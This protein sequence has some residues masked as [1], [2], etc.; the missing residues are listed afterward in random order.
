MSDG[1]KGLDALL[2]QLGPEELAKLRQR[3]AKKGPPKAGAEV[4]GAAASGDSGP[5]ARS[6]SEST[7]EPAAAPTAATTE[8]LLRPEAPPRPEHPPLSSAQVRLWWL[9]QLDPES[10]AYNV[11][12]AYRLRGPLDLRALESALHWLEARHEVL[13]TTYPETSGQPWQR[14]EEAAKVPLPVVDLAALG[15]ATAVSELA[16]EL[17]RQEAARPFRLTSGPMLR[18]LLVRLAAE[19][20]LLVVDLHHIAADQRSHELLVEELA[21]AY[22]ALAAG[23][24]L[25]IA[26]PPGQFI[27]FV[28][29]TADQRQRDEAQALEAQCRILEGAPRDFTLP[30]DRP[31]P[32]QRRGHGELWRYPLDGALS[33]P[34]VALGIRHGASPF[35]TRLALT[36][37]TL[38]RCAARDEAVLAVPVTLRD[39]PLHHVVGFF[40]NTALLRLPMADSF[41]E[42]LA[43]AVAAVSAAYDHRHL[44]FEALVEALRGR[45]DPSLSPL[46][47]VM[48]ATQPASPESVALGELELTPLPL[49]PGG[50]KLDVA[51]TFEDSAPFH[52]LMEF[53]RDL[54]DHSTLQRFIQ[55]WEGLARSLVERGVESSLESLS[56]LADSERQQLLMEW[57]GGAGGRGTAT[58]AHQLVEAQASWQPDA[59]AVIQE[60][61]STLSYG[62]LNR[63]ANRLA[64]EL[65]DLGVSAE[66][67]VALCLPRDQRL[68]VAVVAVL[69]AGAGWLPL[70]PANPPARLRQVVEDA[71]PAVLLTSA[72]LE[73]KLNLEVPITRVL[74]RELKSKA[75]TVGDTNLDLP[76]A[77]E[78]LAYVIYTSGSTGR[79]KGVEVSHGSLATVLSEL[80]TLIPLPQPLTLAALTSLAFDVSVLDLLM[81]LAFGGRLLL[82]SPQSALDGRLLARILE[83]HQ[84]NVLQATPASWRLLREAREKIEDNPLAEDF[85]AFVGGEALTP[86]LARW[87]RPRVEQLWHVY[88]PTEATVL[89][90]GAEVSGAGVSEAGVSEEVAVGAYGSFP[91][92]RGLQQYRLLVVETFAPGAA[93]SQRLAPVGVPGELYL[94]GPG[95]ARGYRQRPARTALAFVP[96][97]FAAAVGAAGGERLYRTGDLVRWTPRGEL[98]FLGRRDDQIKVRGFRVELGEVEARLAAHS[99][100]ALAA[101]V[102]AGEG[103]KSH[104]A[105][106]VELVDGDSGELPPEQLRDF[107][108]E[109]LPGYMVPSQ[110]RAVDALPLTPTGKVDRRKLTERAQREAGGIDPG[111]VVSSSSRP[112]A[113]GAESRVAALMAEV[114]ERASVGAEEDFFA[115]GGHSLLAARLLARLR[116]T[117]GHELPAARFYA[118]PTVA[119]LARELVAPAR[120]DV[121]PLPLRSAADAEEAKDGA[122]SA[123]APLAFAQ[124]R[125]LFHE[126]LNPGAT[127]YAIPMRLELVGAVDPARLQQALWT[128]SS[129]HEALR[130]RFVDEAVAKDASSQPPRRQPVQRFDAPLQPLSVVDLS[131]LSPELAESCATALADRSAERPFDL[132]SGPPVR[133]FWIPMP[134]TPASASAAESRP[135]GQLVITIHHLVADARTLAVLLSELVAL[136]DSGASLPP[137]EVSYG[138]YAR[139]QRSWLQGEALERRIASYGELLGPIPEPLLLPADHRRPRRRG[140]AGATL[141]HAVAPARAAA[142]AALARRLAVSPFAVWLAAFQVTVGRLAG[143]RRFLLGTPVEGRPRRALENTVGLFVNTLPLPADLL[144]AG[145][146]PE[147]GAEGSGPS[148]AATFAGTVARSAAALTSVLALEELPLEKLVEALAPP[149]D[150]SVHPLFEVL[151]GLQPAPLPPGRTVALG[152]LE[153]R[154][155]PLRVKTAKFDLT[156]T[157]FGDATSGEALELGFEYRRDLFRQATVESLAQRFEVLLGSAL[158]RPEAAVDQLAWISEAE[159]RQLLTAPWGGPA[160]PSPELS[161]EGS[162]W[163]AVA[164]AAR[165]RP[166][167]VALRWPAEDEGRP[168]EDGR[169]ETWTYGQLLAKAAGIAAALGQEMARQGAPQGSPVVVCAPPSPGQVAALLAAAAVGSPYVPLDP[170]YPA[171][172]LAHTL[173][174]VAAQGAVVLLAAESAGASLEQAL[175]GLPES[176][177]VLP[178]GLEQALETPAEVS[179]DPSS[180]SLPETLGRATPQDA[181]YVIY[182]SGSTGRPKGVVV[183]HGNALWLLESA[184][185]A[186]ELPTVLGMPD[187]SAAASEDEDGADGDEVW[188]VFHSFAFDFA[189]WELW[190]ALTRGATALLLP[191]ELARDPARLVPV[192][193]G[194]GVSV[195]S[196]TPS[197]WRG[198]QARWLA[199]DQGLPSPTLQRVVFGGEALDESSLLPWRSVTTGG[200]ALGAD[201]HRLFRNLYGITETTVHVTHHPVE[202]ESLHQGPLYPADGADPA[203]GVLDSV[204]DAPA[205][206]AIGSPLEGASVLVVDSAGAPAPPGVKGELWVGGGGV[207][208]GY[209]GRPA[210][211]AWRFVPDPRCGHGGAEPGSRAYRSGDA[212]RWLPSSDSAPPLLEHRGRLD[213][214]LKIRGHRIE[215][216]EVESTLEQHPAVASA[217]VV[218]LGGGESLGVA[219]VR[220]A[221][222]AARRI[223]ESP[224]DGELPAGE[225]PIGE[226]ADGEIEVLRSFARQQLPAALVPDRWRVLESLPL[227]PS[228]KLDRRAVAALLESAELTAPEP[229]EEEGVDG[230]LEHAVARAFAEELGIDAATV[231]RRFHFFDAGGHSLAAV[232]VAQELE[233]LAGY[234][235]PLALLFEAPTPMQLARRMMAIDL[236]H[237]PGPDTVQPLEVEERS[238]PPELSFG[239][240]S[241]WHLARRRAGEPESNA[242]L[243]ASSYNSAMLL[244]LEGDLDLGALQGA[245]EDLVERH[246]SLRTRFPQHRGR[247]YQHIEAPPSAGGPAL[248]LHLVK[249]PAGSQS[250]SQGQAQS[251]SGGHSELENQAQELAT[252][253][254]ARPFDLESGPLVRFQLLALAPRRH[255]LLLCMHHILGD[256]V[257]Y[258]VLCRE[259]TER[260]ELRRRS[261]EAAAEGVLAAAVEAISPAPFQ[262]ADHAAWQRKEA[263]SGVWSEAL[264]RRVQELRDAEPLRLPADHRPPA[265]PTAAGGVLVLHLGQG[266]QRLATALSR[267]LGAGGEEIPALTPFHAVLAAFSALAQRLRGGAPELDELLRVYLATVADGRVR[268]ELREVVGYL[269]NTVPLHLEAVEPAASILSWGRAA[270]RAA[271]AGLED[272]HLPFER[273]MEELTAAAAR[274]EGPEPQSSTGAAAPRVVLQLLDE[275]MRGVSEGALEGSVLTLPDLVA[276]PRMLD[277]ETAKTD[278]VLTLRP[279]GPGWVSEW[280]WSADRHD[281]AAVA[282][283]SRALAHWLEAFAADPLR[284]VAGVSLLDDAQRRQLLGAVTSPSTDPAMGSLPAAGTLW[285]LVR[286]GAAQRGETVAL[287]VAGLAEEVAD[288]AAEWT[289]AELAAAGRRVAAALAAAGARRGEPVLVCAR[290][291]LEQVAAMVG[292]TAVGCPYV[293]LDPA[294]PAARLRSTAADLKA[295][296]ARYALVHEEMQEGAEA[297]IEEALTPLEILPL[298]EA[299]EG[300]D[301]G[302]EAP[303]LGRAESEDGAYVIY[304]SGS[305]GRPKGVVVSHANALWLLRS[306][307]AAMASD[308]DGDSAEAG[309]EIASGVWSICHSF[310]FDFA[311]WELWGALAS[312]ATAL[313]LPRELVRDPARLLPRLAAEGVTVLSQTP[314]AWSL[315]Q[316]QLLLGSDESPGDRGDGSLATSPSRSSLFSAFPSLRWVLFGGEALEQ[317]TLEPVLEESLGAEASGAHSCEA[318]L[319]GPRFVNLYGITETTVHVTWKPLGRRDL[320]PSQRRRA[321]GSPVGRPLPGAA[322]MVVDAAGGIAPP[323]VSGEL[324][325]GGAGVARGYLGRPGLTAWRFVPDPRCGEDSSNSLTPAVAPGSRAYRSGDVGRW[326]SDGELEHRGRR[327]RQLKIRGHRIEAGEVEAA[328]RELP[329]VAAAVVDALAG[330]TTEPSPQRLVAWVVPAL[331]AASGLDR[332][333]LRR[334][335]AARLP[336]PLVPELIYGLDSLP[337]T[338]TGKLDR[339]ALRS[340]PLPDSQPDIQ[341]DSLPDPD[342]EAASEQAPEGASESRPSTDAAVVAAVA[343]LYAQVLKSP[344]PRAEDDFFDLGGNSITAAL[345]TNA[346]QAQLG[347]IVHVVAVFDHPRVEDLAGYLLREHPRGVRTWLGASAAPSPVPSAD[348][349]ASAVG[350]SAAPR[351]DDGLVSRLQGL[352]PNL[353]KAAPG[354][355]SSAAGT[356]LKPAIF[357][358]AP[359]RSGTTLLRV[360]LGGHRRLFAPPE[361]ELLRFATLAQRHET[362]DNDR[363]RF[364]LEGSLRA[365]MELW[366]V[367]LEEAEEV[368][369]GWR[370]LGASTAEVYGSFQQR[371]GDRL[372]VDKT[373]SYALSMETLE[374]AEELFDGALFLHL[375]RHPAAVIRS[376]EKARLDQIF[377]R[378]DHRLPASTLAEGLWTLSHRN[379]LRFLEGIPQE[380]QGTLR[381]EDLVRQPRGTLEPVLERFGLEWESAVGDPYGDLSGRMTDGPRPESRALGDVKLL[382]REAVDPAA[383]E[384][385]RGEVDLAALGSATRRTA[386]DLG[387]WDVPE[388]GG[389]AVTAGASASA[390]AAVVAEAAEISAPGGA[391]EMKAIPSLSARGQR[392]FP[393]SYAQQRLWFLHRL[394]PRS[395]AY[396]IA[397]ALD[398]EGY[399]EAEDLARTLAAVVERHDALR[400]TFH[401]AR[402]AD[403]AALEGGDRESSGS[404]DSIHGVQRISPP[405]S[406]ARVLPLVDLEDLGGGRR[407]EGAAALAA[408]ALERREARRPFD[409]ELGPPLRAVLLRLHPRRHR[410]LLTVHHGVADGWS[411][412]LLLADIAAHY[413]ARLRGLTPSL[414]PL[415]VSYGD[416][417]SWQRQQLGGEA[418]EQQLDWWRERLETIPRQLELPTDRPRPTLPVGEAPPAALSHVSLSRSALTGLEQLA[419]AHRTT[420]FGVLTAT[421]GLALCRLSGQSSA[422]LGFPVAHRTHPQ[423]EP[424]VGYFANTLA[425]PVEV[426][427]HGGEESRGGEP[428]FGELLTA[429]RDTLRGALEHQDLPFERLSEE[430]DAGASGARGAEAPPLVSVA[431]ALQEAAPAQSPELP[432]LSVELRPLSSGASKFDW[433]FSLWRPALVSSASTGS[434]SAGTGGLD[435]SLEYRSDLWDATTIHRVLELWRR[436][437][438]AA[439]QSPELAVGQLPWMSAAQRHQILREWNAGAQQQP[440]APHVAAAF[441]LQVRRNPGATALRQGELSWSYEELYRRAREAAARLQRELAPSLEREQPVAV[442]LP[443]GPS[444][445]AA[446][447]ALALAG[448]PAVP[449]DPAHPPRRRAQVLALSGAEVVIADAAAAAELGSACAELGHPSPRFFLPSSLVPSVPEGGAPDRDKE[450]S[451]IASSLSPHRALYLHF[452]SGSTGEPKGV[453]VSHGAVLA[454]FSDPEFAPLEPRDVVFGFASLAFDASILELWGPLLA[455]ACIALAPAGPLGAQ[456]VVGALE[457]EG[458]TVAWLT[459]G[460]FH[461]IPAPSFQRLP[462]L[463]RLLAGGDVL[464]PQQVQAVRQ[465]RPDLVLVNG[466]GPTENTTF[467]AC[468]VIAPL[469]TAVSGSTSGPLASL[470]PVPVG[471]PVAGGAAWVADAALRPLPA[472]AR[473]ELVASG[474]GLARGY[475]GDPRLTADRFRPNSKGGL[476][477]RLYRTGDFAAWRGDG[478]LDFFGRGDAQLKIRGFRVEP[479]EVESHLRGFQE[480][481]EALVGRH[482]DAAGD[483]VLAAWIVPAQQGSVDPAA[484]APQLAAQLRFLLP[485]A[486]IPAAWAV[487]EVLPLT[488]N[489]KVDRRGL[490]Q[491]RA[492]DALG[493]GSAMEGGEAVAG[494]ET[495]LSATPLEL[496]LAQ[497][498]SEAL[499]R[500]GDAPLGPEADFF[501]LGGHSLLATGLIARIRQRFSVDLPLARLFEN[502]TPR[503]LAPWIEAEGGE[504]ERGESAAAVVAQLPPIQRRPRE[505]GEALES[506]PLTLAPSMLAPLSYAQERLWVLDRFDPGNPAYN[507]PVALELAGALRP[508]LLAAALERVEARHEGLR[509]VLEEVEEGPRQRVLPSRCRALPTVDLSGLA[510]DGDGDSVVHRE[511]ESLLAR[512]ALHRFSLAEGPLL[513]AALLRLAPR[514][515]LLSIVMHHAVSDGWSLGVLQRDVATAYSLL[516]EEESPSAAADAPP[517]PRWEPLAVQYPDFAR[518][519]RQHLQGEVL[520]LLLEWWKERLAAVPPVLSLPTDR[521]RPAVQSFTG[522]HFR[523]PV[524][525][526]TAE[527]L[528]AFAR[529][530]RCT[531][532]AVLAAV[533]GRLLGTLAGATHGPVGMPVAG[534]RRVELEPLVGFF[535]NT[536]VLPLKADGESSLAAAAADSQELLLGALE[537]QDL[538]FET[539]VDALSPQRNLAVSPLFQVMLNSLDLPTAPQPSGVAGSLKGEAGSE[540]DSGEADSGE[541]GSG[542][543]GSGRSSGEE[544][545]VNVHPTTLGLSKFD[546]GLTVA[547]GPQAGDYRFHWELSTALFD[548]TTVERWSRTYLHLLE[549]ALAA[550][551]T[552]FQALPWL[553]PSQRHQALVEWGTAVSAVGPRRSSSL[554]WER[555]GELARREPT[556]AALRWFSESGELQS[557]SR[558]QLEDRRRQLASALEGSLEE[559]GSA[560]LGDPTRRAL[561][562]LVVISLPRGPELV[563]TILAALDLGIAYLP[564]DPTYPLS[565]R[566]TTVADAATLGATAMVIVAPA[567]SAQELVA[568]VEAEASESESRLAPLGVL[569]PAQVP[570][571][572]PAIA[573]RALSAPALSA[574]TPSMPAYVLYTSGST[575]RPKGV[576]VSRA[577]LEWFCAAMDDP[578]GAAAPEGSEEPWLAVTSVAF[579]ISVLE[580]LWTLS[581]G[582]TVALNTAAITPG[583]VPADS[584]APRSETARRPICFSLLY[585]ASATTGGSDEDDP[586]RLLLEGARF[587]DRH[588]FEAVW[589]PERHFHAFGG[590]YPN[591]SVVSAAIAATTERVGLRAGSVVAPLHDPIRTA[592]EWSVVDNLSGG[593]VGVS[594]ASGWHADD[595][596]FQPDAF[597]QRKEVM[598][599]RVETVRQ[600]WR[601]ESVERLNGVGGTVE[602]SI[603]PPPVQRDLPVWLTAAGNPETFRLAG[604]AGSGVLTHLLGQGVRELGEKITVYR[605]AYQEAYAAAEAAHG[606]P[607]PSF[608]H[609]PEG[610]VTLMLHTFVGE[611]LEEVKATVRDPFL[612]YLASSTGLLRNLATSLGMDV[613]EGQLSAQELAAVQQ[614][615][616][617]RYFSTAGLMGTPRSVGE[618]VEKLR[619][620]G[621]DE[622]ACLIDFGVATDQVL[623]SLTL[624]DEVRRGALLPQERVERGAG[625]ADE[626][627]IG[628]DSE[629][630]PAAAARAAAGPSALALATGA[631][632]LQCVPSLVPLLRGEEQGPE[633]LAGLRELVLGGEALPPALL[634]SLRQEHPELR[635]TNVYG[636]TEATVWATSRSL[637][638]GSRPVLA[639]SGVSLG[640]PLAGASAHVLDAALR[641]LPPGVRGELWIGGDGIAMGYLGQPRRTAERFRPDPFASLQGGGGRIYGT[642]DGARFLPDGDLDFL[643]RLDDQVKIRGHRIEPGEI[644]ATLERHPAVGAAAVDVRPGPGGEARLV[645]YVVAPQGAATAPVLQVSPQEREQLL[646]S[647]RRYTLPNGMTVAHHDGRQVRAIYREIFEE[648]TYRRQG[649]RFEDDAVILDIGAN[650]GFFALLASQLCRPERILCFEPLPPNYA[651][652]D[653]N[654][655]LYGR[656]VTAFQQGVG[657][658]E[659]E[660]EFTFFPR[661]AG[662]SGRYGASGADRREILAMIQ[663]GMAEGSL[664]GVGDAG[665]L[666]SQEEIDAVVESYLETETF[667]CPVTTVSSILRREGLERVDLLKIDVERAELEVLDGIG[668]EDWP[669][670]RQL[671]LEVHGPELLAAVR[672]RLEARSFQLV[673]D[674]DIAVPAAGDAPAVFVYGVYAY[675][676]EDPPAAEIDESAPS[677]ASLDSPLLDPTVLKLWLGERLP[678]P[679]VPEAFVPLDA[680]PRT[681]NG[682]LDRRALPEPGASLSDAPFVAPRSALEA[683]IAEVWREILELE[684]VGIDDNFFE[685]GGNSLSLARVAGRLREVLQRRVSIVELFR[686]PT[687]RTLAAHWLEAGE[688]PAAGALSAGAASAATGGAAAEIPSEAARGALPTSSPTP[689][690][691]PSTASQTDDPEEHARRRR[692][693]MTSR[694]S[695]R[696]RR[697]GE[698]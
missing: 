37:L 200:E 459:A 294:Y 421:F 240:R 460:L 561:G 248:P 631:S 50:T 351:V 323:E 21:A 508:D 418:L 157:L 370:Q 320:D 417:A 216:G 230:P 201:G 91:I 236:A 156:V 661:A 408:Q 406:A 215:A 113:P 93:A 337:L 515:H 293:P 366:D 464:S 367:D 219:V 668:D 46:A 24:E 260:Y 334:E 471:R 562:P 628:L 557:W 577:N 119:A 253:A 605:E 193:V 613:G 461:Q 266:P 624:L 542:E 213:H 414:P 584:L 180:W 643:G 250:Q 58:R 609:G 425:L 223:D 264:A 161:A 691:S 390:P 89:S 673:V 114:L 356:R 118:R 271:V 125:L 638:A 96:D 101:V 530:H 551:E 590:L 226:P 529:R 194:Q 655:R 457:S 633:A 469:A 336:E 654:T 503:A 573:A 20:H 361:L 664:E 300:V 391:Q 214:Q 360:M 601:G 494:A 616:F 23:E 59:V 462:Q 92:G 279:Q 504:A 295:C 182:T 140:E 28:L 127:A 132:A 231:H 81:P 662:L 94:G 470:A 392:V 197:A 185:A 220:A 148:C 688:S 2:A 315:L 422:L 388:S 292:A 444:A 325:V 502:P 513:E 671:V 493:S 195:L 328:L 88:G 516:V 596:I 548:R 686:F 566:A 285:E 252:A 270:A 692:E 358:L 625:L 255:W 649:I 134:A 324:W 659:A 355:R 342:S 317:A 348:V 62:A 488:P 615:A 404:N 103:A 451:V 154:A 268:R 375:V 466:Y 274:A 580:I 559:L 326:R 481:A 155:L 479:G 409:L 174:D 383:A 487:L 162:L 67:L 604:S 569:D 183:T 563:A 163:H 265:V 102:L 579:D 10:T 179:L 235:I 650:T 284:P 610:R 644:A 51:F 246:E 489:G 500:E 40:A 674:E 463:R 233:H 36:A 435:G 112:P 527:A 607:P 221:G 283:W 474:G 106:F 652:L 136:Y 258:V 436:L 589:T 298:G 540:A 617:E 396:N 357:V 472:G 202:L 33:E 310:A 338:P 433:T 636:P 491:P 70:D 168:T 243:R 670:I 278:L 52:L 576:V 181:A 578:L 586:Y 492:L 9:A 107:V 222:I 440:A 135:G 39:G 302:P 47:Q 525:A 8:A 321:L 520:D 242:Q 443:R 99:A 693:A 374:R 514:R 346:L 681:P 400:T 90:S 110:L 273:L 442:Q 225:L 405:P 277:S 120:E 341:P 413:G 512:R 339:R 17:A 291:S 458:A 237:E 16:E 368:L 335:L 209:L 332:R 490:P 606:G 398:L 478:R 208:R 303:F 249:V 695:R 207:A 205:G 86:G 534:R 373:P 582:R 501:A 581:R 204:S 591:P 29:A 330:E 84:V 184:V 369:S 331:G 477:S 558:Q 420:L 306:A 224:V 698:E 164:A 480:V 592:E 73:E 430:L 124:E 623:E 57:G 517:S 593:R 629:S 509:V 30:P 372:L 56:W 177:R 133:W 217:V 389:D 3:L 595:F 663:Q 170:E 42:L 397:V 687:V 139:W 76:I 689:A 297:A 259:L 68:V 510:A 160:A 229:G 560:A 79:P 531:P 296:G 244:D 158:A 150:P 403:L 18:T 675:R 95:L 651:I 115:L 122:D 141:L 130:S 45:R 427:R 499:G 554:P 599:E 116:E 511:V 454:L 262:A 614:P 639:A 677:S 187:G 387:Y 327:D 72:G 198:V 555:T 313:L 111:E 238:D 669:K 621:V 196:Q 63:R 147:G 267:E 145:L 506:A 378:Y 178:L 550:P 138:D 48:V 524:P 289:Y 349:E 5:A 532:F 26:P 684:T 597:G 594:F 228:G 658:E 25:R 445:V 261:A 210:L 159:A 505:S 426:L 657:A 523:R 583:M 407:G 476:G 74:D 521:P 618:T 281:E 571:L 665:A 352:V 65:R 53:D 410:L 275:G 647:H 498:W 416:Y 282:S 402:E 308:G 165:R 507:V 696:R 153:G 486:M 419:R 117:F 171:A 75:G 363:D 536:L 544:L 22:T 43:S 381:F 447:V 449:L 49:D 483:A 694:R 475:A 535:A 431:L 353:L 627:E 399:L 441:L 288:E 432:G 630:A 305:T 635:V 384:A 393:L 104:L 227:T 640:R 428:S 189:V 212:G 385:W 44:P 61:G 343:D 319:A 526:A 299:L 345:V 66:S 340:I 83:Q 646:A 567:A 78:Q 570:T 632:G 176:A 648:N 54:Y 465:Q 528:T 69:K 98:E 679:M 109:A 660:V 27:D 496:S 497:L 359:P 280:R 307:L 245:L 347:E 556:A 364:W 411:L 11:P 539:L 450:P 71:A 666:P 678:A 188:T 622:I 144:P 564:L 468:E 602:L 656:G 446:L 448:A 429:V 362:F 142:V 206:S 473:G 32:P 354:T 13:R 41:A 672:Q 19:D 565:R 456:E 329:E 97:A 199:A 304:T 376:F 344:A 641:P 608:P 15:V 77:A 272:Q 60:D 126:R 257:S 123:A 35:A 574:P 377:F 128:L 697:R 645:A 316:R 191:R 545:T 587:A 276:R 518:W 438:T 685:V 108:A 55:R 626:S 546:L 234:P 522:D 415:A 239:Q 350:D 149:R 105:A 169:W 85:C 543:E 12:A 585:F 482:R 146:P 7:A 14:V 598:L 167:A 34:L 588:G 365:V 667:R 311:V 256:A 634:E 549:A 263:L 129:R 287:R 603:L 412:R 82:L 290:P 434:A 318:R 612:G 309:A 611:D 312:S 690:S 131:A 680:L 251:Q 682:K 620:L 151:F 87:L 467:T 553:P 401:E 382:Q 80:R 247:P 519:Q 537:H 121:P 175:E 495:E 484:L 386:R 192:L 203:G 38:A 572:G 269:V 166:E 395:A 653:V 322:V 394:Q 4:P 172:R 619:A 538:P 533:L 379:I 676:P 190:G 600:L 637:G 439:A 186:L 301:P 453:V 568:A 1:K 485:A 333:G 437:A 100:V 380:R 173:T 552:P 143:R 286:D 452:T 254:L 314:T 211:T 152:A 541:E 218:A 6:A 455:G 64:R 423:V 31:R 547:P 642:G 683:D 575:G 232:R 241:L 371:L 137:V 424:L